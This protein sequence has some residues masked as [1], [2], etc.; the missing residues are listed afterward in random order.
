MKTIIF[1]SL[2]LVFVSIGCDKNNKTDKQQQSKYPLVQYDIISEWNDEDNI[3][4]PALW[5]SDDGNQA[6]VIATSKERHNLF[7]YD[8]NNL[9]LLKQIGKQGGGQLEFDRPNGIWVL[10][11]Y[12]FVCERDNH[13][14]QVISLPDFSFVG[15]VGDNSLIRPYGLSVTKNNDFYNLFVTDN[16]EVENQT[17]PPYNM[18]NQRVQHYQFKIQ[19]NSL[20][21]INLENSFGDTLGRGQLMI[22]ESIYADPQY[23]RLLIAEEDKNQN[24]V[25]IF[26]MKGR[27]LQQEIGEDLIQYQAEGIMMYDCGNGNGFYF[28]TDQD[29]YK[30]NNNTFHIYSRKDLKYI[31]SFISDKIQ[32]TDG[33]WVTNRKFGNFDN[34]ALIAVNDDGGVAII[35]I[36]KIFNTL[37][38]DCK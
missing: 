17:Y 14:V 16:F 27:F 22:V 7:V 28:L 33:I 37:K 38:I 23:N 34:G 13:R 21:D 4:S 2:F 36:R 1:L 29:Y 30:T 11:N 12:L 19:N 3:D 9:K 10:D 8:A 25:K 24:V 26:D 35:D 31:G 5:I 18:L 6:L 20:V 15:F 32:N